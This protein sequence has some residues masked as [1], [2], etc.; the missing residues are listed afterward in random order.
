MAETKKNKKMKKVTISEEDIALLLQRYS[1]TTIIT[2]LQEVAQFSN[3]YEKI[4]WSEVVKKTSTGITNARE[5]Q[6]VW[7]HLAYRDNLSETV[8]DVIDPLD[9]DSDLESYL[10]VFPPVSAKA[11]V[12]AAAFAK[13]LLG[14]ALPSASGPLDLL[15][16]EAPLTINIPTALDNPQP[17]STQ[18]KNIMVPVSVQ[19]K[20]T[21]SKKHTKGLLPLLL[22]SVPS[23]EKL[24][25]ERG[26]SAAGAQRRNE[27]KG[28]LPTVPTTKGL[29]RGGSTAGL[30]SRKR[31]WQPDEDKELIAAVQRYGEGNWANI[32]KGDFKADRTA[33]QLSQRWARLRKQQANLNLG[34]HGNPANS[35][36]TAEQLATRRAVSHALDMP[37]MDKFSG[38]TR[39]QSSIPLSS[40]AVPCGR[41][42]TSAQQASMSTTTLNFN[43]VKGPAVPLKPLSGSDAMIQAAAVAA[44]A[45][46]VTPST[47]A[48]LLKCRTKLI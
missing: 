23:T 5:Y 28:S 18:S 20:D 43:S 39:T 37:M 33:S 24:E 27:Q 44:G 17:A 19:R 22:P 2:L 30:P 29:K 15:A 1:A 11:S 8:D 45:R 13:V 9:D 3:S 36:L 10:E 12:E 16:V 32:L 47:A 42:D 4:D 48:S 31:R 40:A 35:Q 34:G 41:E 14:S 7:R 21:S 38:A 6:M 46:I 25:S 26:E